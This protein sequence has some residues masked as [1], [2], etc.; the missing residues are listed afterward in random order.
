MRREA[1]QSLLKVIF[2][3]LEDH[4]IRISEL[5]RAELLRASQSTVRFERSVESPIDSIEEAARLIGVARAS[6]ELE[7]RLDAVLDLKQLLSQA[8]DRAERVAPRMYKHALV[9]VYEALSNTYA[10]DITDHQFEVL[11]VTIVSLRRTD[12]SREQVRSIASS[13]RQA[14]LRPVPV[15]TRAQRDKILRSLGL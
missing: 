11:E 10:E 2:R 12:L 13:L 1:E 8:I 4:G 3:A 14:G 6:A 9:I 5:E 7:Q 15:S